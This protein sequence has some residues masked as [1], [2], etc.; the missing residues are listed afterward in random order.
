MK[1]ENRQIDRKQ[2]DR[3]KIDGK[4]ENRQ[5]DRKQ[6]DREINIY[7]CIHIYIYKDK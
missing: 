3:Q 1:F 2:K 4:I 7:G 5:E 6:M